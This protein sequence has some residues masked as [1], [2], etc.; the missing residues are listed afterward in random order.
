M[1]S[2]ARRSGSSSTC[3]MAP[4]IAPSGERAASL[5]I[6]LRV[7]EER[8]RLGKPFWC[9]PPFSQG[10]GFREAASWARQATA[11]PFLVEL[12][13]ERR[14]HEV[15][16][17]EGS[18]HGSYRQVSECCPWSGRPRKTGGTGSWTT[19]RLVPENFK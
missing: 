15:R 8:C 5:D 17:A 13:K 9:L 7:V 18:F 10:A 3:L 2:L 4:A 1:A 6:M 12:N 14:P 11:I 19:G 16:V